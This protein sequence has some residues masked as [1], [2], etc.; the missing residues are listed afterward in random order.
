MKALVLEKKL[1]LN[2]RDIDL[3]NKVGSNDVNQW[4]WDMK[5]QE[6]LSK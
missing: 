5:A 4:F 3:P 1:E 6:Q 2:L